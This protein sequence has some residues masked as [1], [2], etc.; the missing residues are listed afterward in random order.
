MLTLFVQRRR[1][2]RRHAVGRHRGC[3]HAL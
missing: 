2:E 3:H 1:P